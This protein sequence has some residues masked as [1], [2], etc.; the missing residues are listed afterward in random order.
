MCYLIIGLPVEIIFL[1][2]TNLNKSFLSKHFWHNASV[3]GFKSMLSFFKNIQLQLNFTSFLKRNYEIKDH[4]YCFRKEFNSSSITSELVSLR[5]SMTTVHRSPE[6]LLQQLTHPIS[7]RSV[8]SKKSH[9]Q[10]VPTICK[11][12]TKDRSMRSN[13]TAMGKNAIPFWNTTS[14]YLLIKF[15]NFNVIYILLATEQ[16]CK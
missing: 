9:C 14:S 15:M 8:Q 12:K 2:Q 3:R 5:T 10:P 7:H 4:F 16:H 11:S 13:S 6:T 1:L